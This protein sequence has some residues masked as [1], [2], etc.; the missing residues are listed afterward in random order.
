MIKESNNSNLFEN[1][2]AEFMLDLLQDKLREYVQIAIQTQ[3][4]KMFLELF[5]ILLGVNID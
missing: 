5:D 2:L 4:S 1:D 3:S